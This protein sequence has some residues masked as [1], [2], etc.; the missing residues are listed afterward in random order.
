MYGGGDPRP[1]K[2][3]TLYKHKNAPT[4]AFAGAN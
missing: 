4:F 2:S 3:T 1:F